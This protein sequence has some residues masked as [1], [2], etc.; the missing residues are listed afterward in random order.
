MKKVI[1]L[2]LTFAIALGLC[3]CGGSGDNGGSTEPKADGL[4]V[5]YARESILPN[6]QVN[7]SG[8]GNQGSRISTE[9][10]DILYATCLAISENGTTILLFSTDTLTAKD[11]W[12]NEARLN[13]SKATGV[14]AENI[15][16][17][18][19]HTH[20][21]P[22]V[23]GDEALVKQWKPVYM[24]A[25]LY[26]AQS[27]IADQAPSTLYAKKVQTEQMAFVRHFKMDDGSYA[28]SNFGDW[29][30]TAVSQATEADEEM[31][32]VKIDREGDKKK[33]IMLMNFQAHP[34]FGYDIKMTALTADYISVA[35]NVFEQQTGMK[36]IYFLG[37]AGNQN[38]SSRISSEN[39]PHNSDM[40][41]YGT[42]L[43]QYA[44]DALPTMTT[45]VEGAGV[46]TTKVM[47][48]YKCNDYGQDR[49]EDARKVNKMFNETGNVSSCNAY[50]KSLGFYSVYQCNGIVQCS[51]LPASMEM[52]LNAC[53]FGGIGFVA[54]SYEMFSNSAMY[55]KENSPFEYTVI[56]T[57]TNGYNNYFP[58]KEAF[59]YGCYESY[60]ARFGS[61]VAEDTA[62]KFVEMLKTVQ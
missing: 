1:S 59:E 45:P 38:T 43:A 51:N 9:N 44:I 23:G 58:T 41:Q 33:D 60:T 8:L 36:F 26:A 21:G 2:I 29:T 39:A 27:A 49:L 48:N 7:M 32:L 12:T 61:G 30:K 22:A 19:T 14:P 28:G 34:C 10:L 37:S 17:G 18:G 50:A 47:Y 55:I 53:S 20:S 15:Q 25:L 35:R 31:I 13:I 57:C 6:G 40:T 3:A 54:A 16:I 52:E 46:K 56:S 24:N 62:A 42:K 11:N 5:G 4:M